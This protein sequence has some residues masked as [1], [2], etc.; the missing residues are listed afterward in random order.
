ME[1]EVDCAKNDDYKVKEVGTVFKVNLEAKTQHLDHHL[2]DK[3][4]KEDEVCP[5]DEYEHFNVHRVRVQ[6]QHNSV[7]NDTEAYESHEKAGLLHFKTPP[8]EEV[9]LGPHL[10]DVKIQQSICLIDDVLHLILLN[11]YV[12]EVM[13]HLGEN[14]LLCQLLVSILF[15]LHNQF[16]LLHRPNFAHS[17]P[18]L[19]V[20]IEFKGGLLFVLLLLL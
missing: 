5:L 20:V 7:R 10:A 6:S 3:D 1:D 9:L 11:D 16:N 13:G 19:H 14:L 18:S 15:D 17:Q 8:V 2:S 12:L 4:Q